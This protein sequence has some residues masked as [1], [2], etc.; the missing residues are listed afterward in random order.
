MK[1]AVIDLRDGQ[2]VYL[3][4]EHRL[5]YGV[6]VCTETFTQYPGDN[7]DH[8]G[9]IVAKRLKYGRDYR[10]QGPHLILKDSIKGDWM[11][12]RYEES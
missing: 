8:Y 11:E 4:P 9:D 12:I 2:T 1:F 7:M 6:M 3:L 10:R 5:F